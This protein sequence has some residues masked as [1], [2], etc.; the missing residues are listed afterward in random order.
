MTRDSVLLLSCIVLTGCVEPD[1]APDS[2]NSLC[3]T[4]AAA[5]S[6]P[7]VVHL[8]SRSSQLALVTADARVLGWGSGPRGD[9]TPLAPTEPTFAKG[10]TCARQVAVSGEH[11]CALLTEGTV[12]CWGENFRQELGNVG[13]Q[14]RFPQIVPG[15]D[16]AIA[17]ATSGTRT[18]VVSSSGAVLAWGVPVGDCCVASS[19]EPRVQPF[20]DSAALTVGDGHMCSVDIAGRLSCLGAGSSGQ[21]GGG[22]WET[23]PATPIAPLD[24]GAVV[25]VDAGH[26]TTCAVALAGDVLCWGEILHDGDPLESPCSNVPERIDEIPPASQVAVGVGHACALAQRR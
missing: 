21:L 17:V 20:V 10:I 24:V 12:A 5:A 1:I 25:S 14:T 9:G 4:S 7:S 11:A 18:A 3:P 15:V 19:E 16:A 26:Q 8:D 6:E 2:E 23:S 22:S 13:P